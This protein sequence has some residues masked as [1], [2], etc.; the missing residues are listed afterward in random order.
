MVLHRDQKLSFVMLI[1][2]KIFIHSISV[3]YLVQVLQ[4][5]SICDLAFSMAWWYRDQLSGYGPASSDDLTV[6]HS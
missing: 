3:S 2:P 5:S 6:L 1:I 4:G